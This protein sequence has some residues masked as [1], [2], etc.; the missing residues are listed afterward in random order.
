MKLV[1]K[2]ATKLDA[3]LRAAFIGP[4]GSGK[5]WTALAVARFLAEREKSRVLCIDTERGSASKYGDVFDFD[6]LELSE[7]HPQFYIDALAL[8]VANGYKVIVIDSLSHAWAGKQGALE[9]V[10]QA[11]KRSQSGSTFNAWR[12]VTPLH[13]A[14]VDSILSTKAHVIATMR[15]KTEYVLETNERGRQV[16]KRVGMAPVMRDGISFEF[17]ICGDMTVENELLIDKTRCSALTGK[18]FKKPGDEFASIL[19]NWLRVD[20]P[21]GI[22]TE[23]RVAPA[24]APEPAPA[25]APKKAT[26]PVPEPAPASTAAGAPPKAFL[27]TIQAERKKAGEAKYAAAL[28]SVGITAVEFANTHELQVSLYNALKSA[29]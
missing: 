15:A 22:G 2:K 26:P 8:G 24:P 3:F 19:W 29:N 9:L 12:D 6:S 7:H 14:L 1:I 27:T 20:A 21:A 16:P 18:T 10:D 25:P 13:N 11:A 5:T 17:D 23:P 28:A 4:A